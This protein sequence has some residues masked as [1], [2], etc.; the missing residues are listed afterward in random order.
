MVQTCFN[1]V[2]DLCLGAIGQ[3]FMAVIL[4]DRVTAFQCRQR[5][6][7]VELAGL[8]LK[9]HTMALQANLYKALQAQ[10]K[11]LA[12]LALCLYQ[13]LRLLAQYALLQLLDTG[14]S[15]LQAVLPDTVQTALEIIQT[16]TLLAQPVAGVAQPGAQC[17]QA[18]AALLQAQLHLT[19]QTPLQLVDAE[20]QRALIRA[21]QFGGG[22][23]GRCAVI[24]D[25]IA[26]HHIYFMADCTDDRYLAVKDGAGDTLFVECPQ[27]LQRT[28]AAPDNQNI[29]GGMTVCQRDR[30]LDLPDRLITL[31]G[32]GVQRDR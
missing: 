5:A 32:G 10:M 2:T 19:A 1:R 9:R 15:L 16:L 29:A 12:V 13:S 26:D 7:G 18:F 28:A 11:V 3:Y 31:N 24:G 4:N 23:R 17:V 25:K 6:D 20:M 30:T 21:D 27:I 8:C 22:R 14:V